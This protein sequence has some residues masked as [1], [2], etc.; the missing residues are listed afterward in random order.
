MASHVAS[1]YAANP[2]TSGEPRVRIARWAL[3]IAEEI[4]CESLDKTEEEDE[5]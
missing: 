4:L 2:E 5:C 3:E 1:G